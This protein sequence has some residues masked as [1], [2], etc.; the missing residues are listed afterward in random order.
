MCVAELCTLNFDRVV[1]FFDDG[2]QFHM[3]HNFAFVDLPWDAVRYRAHL[4]R[5]A[6]ATTP[7]AWPCWFL[8]NHDLPRV[9][10]RLAL[11]TSAHVTPYAQEEAEPAAAK[12]VA[13]ELAAAE[14]VAAEPDPALG[15]AR[16]RAVIVMLHA[17][18]GTPFLFEGQ[19][20]G[21]PNAVVSADRVVDVDG[22]DPC[23]A[24]I[25][26]ERPSAAG[27]GA[28][29]TTE[30]WL[31][32]VE[33]AE[34]LAV[35]AQDGDPAATLE[36]T[37]R[38]TALRR[39]T[40]AL[41]TGTQ[42]LHDAAPGVTA[43]LREGEDGESWLV[44]VNTGTQPTTASLPNPP[45]ARGTLVIGSGPTRSTRHPR[46][47]HRPPTPHPR[48][49]RGPARPSRHR[50]LTAAPEPGPHCEGVS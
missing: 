13:A 5:F 8:E 2:D 12:P 15:Q 34:T 45:A 11:G 46:R 31:R 4:E 37:R 33:E 17:L 21:L 25:P 38:L 40:P 47:R 18:R 24:P 36:L 10:S 20:L 7:L 9:A 39:A 48:H 50:R 3:A 1:A 43:W 26:W 49:G 41:Q 42:R 22:R 14:P 30:P 19:E 32:I 23:R 16:A 27:P 44:L 29:F 28:G 6:A 35:A